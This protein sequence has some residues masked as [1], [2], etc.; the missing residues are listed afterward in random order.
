MIA[1]QGRAVARNT[2]LDPAKRFPDLSRTRRLFKG[3]EI[4]LSK[5]VIDE[6]DGRL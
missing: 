6:R 3:R 2:P 5:A 4:A 1:E